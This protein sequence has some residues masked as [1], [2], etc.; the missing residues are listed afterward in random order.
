MIRWTTLLPSFSA[1]GLL[2]SLSLGFGSGANGAPFQPDDWS[3]FEKEAVTS[4]AAESDLMLESKAPR[5]RIPVSIRGFEKV[6]GS[7]SPGSPEVTLGRR[8]HYFQLRARL[9]RPNH[10]Y[11]DDWHVETIPQRAQG[12]VSMKL[13]LSRTYGE[14]RELEEHLGDLVVEGNL[15]R[16][17]S[18]LYLFQGRSAAKFTNRSG[19]LAAEIRVNHEAVGGDE[20]GRNA[21]SD[22][23][24][25]SSLRGTESVN[26]LD[27]RPTR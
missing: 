7:D 25:V 13:S 12:H 26:R 6:P 10:F 22:P 19:D 8:P 23:A 3:V 1:A 14:N 5:V 27:N 18:D 17:T 16:Q 20:G 4:H 9:D 24:R 11:F 21:A 15:L 2:L